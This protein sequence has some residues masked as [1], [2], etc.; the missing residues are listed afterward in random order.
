VPCRKNSRAASDLAS[1]G[2]YSEPYL[3]IIFLLVAFSF[4]PALLVA[5]ESLQE[6]RQWVHGAPPGQSCSQQLQVHEAGPGVYIL[7]QN[8]CSN[9]EAPFMYLILGEKRALLLDTGAEPAAGTTLPLVDTVDRLIRSWEAHRQGRAVSLL[10][11]HSHNHRDH[12]HLDDEFK[13][14]P[15]TTVIGTSVD[16][17]K[18]A[19]GFTHWPDDEVSIDL[20]ERMLS[21]LPLPG[22]EDSHL[23]FYDHRSG[24]LFSGDSLYPGLLTVRDWAAYRQSIARLL[25]FAQRYPVSA[26]AGA[27]IEMSRAPGKMYPLGSPFQPEEHALF[28]RT[29]QLQE[30][31]DALTAQGDKPARLERGDFIVTPVAP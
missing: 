2:K 28:L 23:A 5:Q 22:H 1:A 7:R 12:R 17:V 4:T 9:F 15:N 21:V 6:A 19:F 24:A 16:A 27:H 29:R 18:A 11:A 10:V 26:I 8:K 14:R 20:G 3:K 30:L 25:A 31:Y 13:A